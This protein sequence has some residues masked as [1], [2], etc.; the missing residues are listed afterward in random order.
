MYL[1]NNKL[2]ASWTIEESASLDFG[3]L[4]PDYYARWPR[5]VAQASQYFNFLM[6]VPTMVSSSRKRKEVCGH[7]LQLRG[8]GKRSVMTVVS[9]PI[10]SQKSQ[11]RISLSLF[12]NL[13]S[14]FFKIKSSFID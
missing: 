14:I 8:R 10:F 2:Q 9:V 5:E 13:N 4:P 11:V 6:N 1:K 3:S 7:M 12:L